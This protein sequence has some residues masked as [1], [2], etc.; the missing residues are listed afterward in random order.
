MAVSAIGVG[1]VATLAS[2]YTAVAVFAVVTG[3]AALAA[4]A[5]HVAVLRRG[6]ATRA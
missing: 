2:L 3:A 6:A 5:W 1:I 4:A